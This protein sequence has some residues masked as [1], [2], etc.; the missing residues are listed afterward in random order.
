MDKKYN[1][2]LVLNRILA[3]E[4]A[5]NF[6]L[7][8]LY[9]AFILIIEKLFLTNFLKKHKIFGLFYTLFFVIISFVIFNGDNLTIPISNLKTMFGLNNYPLYNKEIIYYLKSYKY[10]LL[11]A[12]ISST[13]YPKIII[14]NFK[15]NRI[16]NNLI[17]FIEP[18]Y[19]LLLLILVTTFLIDASFNPFLYFRF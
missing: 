6:I 2:S 9:F 3:P 5:C 10:I 12:F 17:S 13:P 1:N 7:W 4:L 15:K 8:G 18:I 19:L 11:L 16:L 14:E